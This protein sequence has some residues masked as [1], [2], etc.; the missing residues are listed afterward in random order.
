MGYYLVC[1]VILV[2]QATEN[3]TISKH[4]QSKYPITD[5]FHFISFLRH[6]SDSVA[7]MDHSET[8]VHL[9]P[10]YYSF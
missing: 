1:E 5:S 2:H 9:E 7:K 8:T 3:E 10:L 6:K 4:L